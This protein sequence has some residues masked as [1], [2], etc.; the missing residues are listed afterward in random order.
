[1]GTPPPRGRLHSPLGPGAGRRWR[2]RRRPSRRPWSRWAAAA[3]PGRVPCTP[4]GEGGGRRLS[5]KT[6]KRVIHTQHGWRLFGGK[7]VKTWSRSAGSE[8]LP[9][10][11]RATITPPPPDA[12]A[13]RVPRGGRVPGGCCRQSPEGRVWSAREQK[14]SRST[15]FHHVFVVL[16]RFLLKAFYQEKKPNL[17]PRLQ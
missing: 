2:P 7:G 13:L 14:V 10:S 1:M 8:R 3:P 12:A 4:R 15:K 11:G 17:L 6:C 9:W 5:G 16:S